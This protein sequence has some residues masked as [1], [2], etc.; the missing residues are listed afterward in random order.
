MFETTNQIY[1][2]I[3]ISRYIILYNPPVTMDSLWY[4]NPPFIVERYAVYKSDKLV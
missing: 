4:A 1:I 2:Y 3:Y